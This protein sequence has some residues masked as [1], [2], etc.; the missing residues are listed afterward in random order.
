MCLAVLFASGV[1]EGVAASWLA[2]RHA[3]T[4]RLPT[5]FPNAP[6]NL[7][8][9]NRKD[10]RAP[11]PLPTRFSDTSDDETLD[12][13]VLGGSSACGVPYHKWLSVGRIVAWKLHAAIPNRRFRVEHLARPGYTLEMVHNLMSG[14][15][16]RPDL[17][18][19]YAGHNEFDGRYNWEQTPLHYVDDTPPARVTLESSARRI[20]PLCRLIQQTTETFRVSLRPPQ[21]ITRPLVNVPVYTAVE[22]ATRLHE[23]RTRLET[24]VSYCER[25]GALVVLLAPPAN[26]AD[27]EPNRSFLSPETTRP[28]RAQ[29]AR[30][31]VTA[32]QI[33]ETD[34]VQGIVAYRDLLARQPGFAE[35][36]Y[37]LARLLEAAGQRE[38]ANQHYVAARD[39]DGFPVRCPSDFLNAY[40]EV[41]T[42]HPR[43]ILVNAPEV[44]RKLSPRG[45]VGDEFIADGHHPSLV[46]YAALS[47]TILEELYARQAFDWPAMSPAPVVTASGCAAHFGM[48]SDKW[49]VVCEFVESFY[50]LSAFVRFDASQ[51]MARADCYLEAMRRIKNGV[52]PETIRIPGIGTGQLPTE[53]HTTAQEPPPGRG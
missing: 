38:E 30:D 5:R 28:E 52:S 40:D 2:W 51:R 48:N 50:E 49:V 4:P 39:D 20:S 46:G 9:G 43:A 1:A 23:F 37:R 26:D 27:F 35:T 14:L 44:L 16:R 22:Y 36:H 7:A 13:V 6:A 21:H 34:P 10:G 33:E 8:F 25:L 42:R 12:I 11:E 41:A 3:S 45:T 31:F 24:I 53:S 15:K 17:V 47:Q 19:V 18:I 32:R 29:F